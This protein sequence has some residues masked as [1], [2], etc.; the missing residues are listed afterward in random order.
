M[1]SLAK[2]NVLI[3][4]DAHVVRTAFNKIFAKLGIHT[5]QAADS[6]ESAWNL[7][8][9]NFDAGKPIDVILCDWYMPGG[10]GIDLLEKLRLSGI[11]GIRLTKFIMVTGAND[12]TIRAIDAGANSVIHKPFTAETIQEKF[13]LIFGPLQP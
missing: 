2:L 7:I 4:D 13:E 11:D 6:I 1:T 5:L 9:K 10:D 12:K 3:V 8:V